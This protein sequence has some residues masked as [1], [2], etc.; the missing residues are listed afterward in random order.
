MNK[1]TFIDNAIIFM[2]GVVMFLFSVVYF[3]LF[4]GWC[5]GAV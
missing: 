3:P 2:I 1:N 5:Y 4:L